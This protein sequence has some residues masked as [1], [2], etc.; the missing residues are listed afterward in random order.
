MSEKLFNSNP[1][2]EYSEIKRTTEEDPHFLE[3]LK[4]EQSAETRYLFGAR[5][6]NVIADLEK[7]ASEEP[8]VELK[9]QKLSFVDQT[10]SWSLNML[11]GIATDPDNFFADLGFQTLTFEALEDS[12]IEQQLRQVYPNA[13]TNEGGPQGETL[14]DTG[15]ILQNIQ[16]MPLP[17][18]RTILE[19]HIECHKKSDAELQK[20]L[21]VM[22]K[23]FIDRLEKKI[24]KQN[25]PV[26]KQQ[27]E[28]K[29]KKV[30]VIAGDYLLY[31]DFTGADG[32]YNCSNAIAV[33]PTG[34]IMLVPT[35][36][37][38]YEKYQEE[39]YTHEMMHAVSAL[40]L[41][42]EQSAE[43][44][45]VG[46]R[47]QRM[48]LLI[49]GRFRWLNEA[50]TEYLAIKATGRKDSNSYKT[51]REILQT[52]IDRGVPEH[53]F[54]EAYFSNQPLALKK[55]IKVINEKCGPQF[56]QDID[57]VVDDYGEEEALQEAKGV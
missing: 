4:K 11:H 38:D 20:K 43:G 15:D 49:E 42:S 52:M 5:E 25:S 14:V 18:Y 6:L 53:L 41:L 37:F 46:M 7:E 51:E 50:V 45:T 9:E 32:D 39:V 33:I 35:P 30:K 10:L 47:I 1:D 17:L 26:S 16:A 12:K 56:L 40:A 2:R 27:L 23:R 22:Q 19:H 24:L 48:G 3:T 55:L 31:S 8:N 34:E 29:M 57:Q 21:P 44:N 36:D 13:F 54:V 28:Q